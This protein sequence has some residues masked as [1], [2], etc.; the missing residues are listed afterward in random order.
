MKKIHLIVPMAGQGTRFE[1]KGFE[2]PKPLIRIQGKPFFFWAVQSVMR[3]IDIEDLRFV[4]LQGHVD[5]YYLDREIIRL[6]PMANIVVIPDVL[7]GAVLTCQEGVK[8]FDDESPILF[9]DCDHAFVSEEFYRFLKRD[10]ND[11][12]DGALLTFES[13]NRNYS[14]IIF[15]EE[16][17]V[18]GTI[19][20]EVVSSEAICGAYFFKNASVFNSAA[21]SYLENC[22]YSEYY[23]SGVYNELVKKH[24]VVEW[25]RVDEHLSFG[26]PEEYENIR[27][28]KRFELFT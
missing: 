2:C 10:N 24:R 12:V 20:K 25:F 6:F 13:D 4:V 14:Y 19:E 15:N 1:E 16:R 5:K 3:Y 7:N 17:Q 11:H 8:D 18:C 22:S 28:D 27:F 26:T 9:N 21:M 23:M